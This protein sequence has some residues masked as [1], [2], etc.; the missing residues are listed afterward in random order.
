MGS[1]SSK[2]SPSIKNPRPGMITIIA[3]NGWDFE[4]PPIKLMAIP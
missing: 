4:V 3:S 2:I 1:S